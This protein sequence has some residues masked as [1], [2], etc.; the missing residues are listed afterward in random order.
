MQKI[1][2]PQPPDVK[3]QIVPN[4]ETFRA[5]AQRGNIVS[6]WTERLA[7]L[8]TPVSAFSKMARDGAAIL[9]ESVQGGERWAAHSFV[10]TRPL[11]R[12]TVESGE[13]RV[14]RDDGEVVVSAAP[15]PLR[16]VWASLERL[17]FAPPV[18]D[19]P[20][21][22]LLAGAVGYLGYDVVRAFEPVG[23]SPKPPLGIPDIDFIVPGIVLAFDNLRQI[24]CV[25]RHVLV[26]EGADL[27]QLYDAAVSD[28]ERVSGELT[29]SSPL[30]QGWHPRDVDMAS[31]PRAGFEPEMERAEF[32]AAVSRA[33]ELI[34]AGD[35]IQ[36]VL[37]QRFRGAADVSAFAV[38]RAL[39]MTNPSP[40]MYYLRLPRPAGTLE[41]AGASPEVLV[42]VEGDEAIVRPIAGT[43]PRGRTVEEDMA[44]AEEMH[45]DPKEIAEHVMLVDLGR[46]DIGRLAQAGTVR[47]AERM[48][49]ERYSH[50]M[51]MVSEVRGKLRDGVSQYDVVRATFPAG[52]LSGAPKVR[53]MQIIE[54]LEPVRRG[55]YGG[56]IGYLGFDG[57][58]DLCI[59]IRTLVSDGAEMWCQAGAGIVADSV[60][61]N[62]YEETINKARAVFHAVAVARRGMHR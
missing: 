39:R 55:P 15:D 3:A 53:A 54:E 19:V 47:V 34:L 43:R 41:I 21:V 11:M 18:G 30:E 58:I 29:G 35:C 49:T 5:L 42:R 60:P 17:R 25:I 7:D 14:A 56:A 38:Y 51:H 8:D 40:Y 59:T 27:D 1:T 24:A 12:L 48:I 36:V 20:P 46:N 13:L 2:S 57:N 50:V 22:P 9:L 31:D 52:T 44:L 4:R 61:E 26:R 45:A 23:D 28:I 6:L 33:R 16:A 10:A 62:E 32:E 37:S